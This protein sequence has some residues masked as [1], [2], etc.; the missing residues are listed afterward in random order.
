LRYSD[1]LIEEVRSANDIVDVIGE[2]VR[3]KRSGNN[4]TGLCPF[5]NEKTPSF[6]VSRTK[7]MYYCFG[8]HAGG[9][10]ITFMMEYNHMTFL[11]ALEALAERAH[12]TLPQIEYSKEAQAQADKKA[13]LLEINKKAAA[14]Y[15][16]LLKT[17]EGEIGLN[18]LRERGL[19][20]ETIKKFGLGYS[21][22]SGRLYSYL[23]NK[24]YSDDLLAETGLFTFDEK[25]GA[26]DKF[27]NR[28]MFPIADVRGKVIGFGGRVMG[29]AKPKYLNS[30][31]T[32]VFNKRNNLFGLNIARATRRRYIILCEGYMDV[33]SMHQAGFDCAVASLGTA[34]TPQQ[35][36]LLK[37]Y[38]TN[39]LLLYDS[40]NAGKMAALRAIPILKDAG[41]E[42]RVV[43]LS[44]YK[45]P[46]EFIKGLGAS[47]LEERLSG[48]SNAFMFEVEDTAAKYR[49]D[50]PAERT[51]FQKAVARMLLQF[52]EELERNNY[53][54]AIAR[55][56]SFSADGLRKMVV[57]M[58]MAGTPAER[59]SEPVSGE[60]RVIREKKD[61]GMVTSQKLMLTYLANYPEAYSE[62]KA[63]IGPS[64]FTDPLC[65]KIAEGLY[66]QIREGKV[67]EAALVNLFIDAEEQTQ[68]AQLFH[69]SI[70]VSSAAEQDKAF[71]DTV[72]RLMQESN[73][74]RM[75]VWDGKN[76]EELTELINQKRRMEEFRRGGKVLH[77]PFANDS[78]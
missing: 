57:R 45:D 76:P 63:Y 64:D 8:C 21:G 20:D 28:V 14:Y 29:D 1:E 73:D 59:Y 6:S 48:A 65:R 78:L 69:T 9:N 70:P 32:T 50:D 18:Y 24:G 19:S 16:Y 77:L 34:L 53:I 13:Q 72:Y 60:R 15:Y 74:A 12:I 37:R 4:Y 49:L 66:D 30:P 38:T 68:A 52:P 55:R 23:K 44:P 56:Y 27:W 36:G 26:M 5:H 11:E 42:S 51:N 43:D 58:A 47:A 31:E 22:R 2:N 54:E 10:V 41:I 17:K 7:Q 25:R 33:I 62:S 46:D 67:S 61:S 40:D 75:K 39:V 71:T 35:A 3:L